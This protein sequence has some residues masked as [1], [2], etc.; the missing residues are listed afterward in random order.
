MASPDELLRV[1]VWSLSGG[2][3]DLEAVKVGKRSDHQEEQSV[4]KEVETEVNRRE[5]RKIL[6]KRTYKSYIVRSHVRQR[7]MRTLTDVA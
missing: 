2:S 4:V 1:V 5:K 3:L 6:M 7:L